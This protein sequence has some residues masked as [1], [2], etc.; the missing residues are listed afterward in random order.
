MGANRTRIP[1]IVNT[2]KGPR[3]RTRMAGESMERDQRRIRRRDAFSPMDRKPMFTQDK[4]ERMQDKDMEARRQERKQRREERKQT[5]GDS[6][7]EQRKERRRSR[8]EM[9][10]GSGENRRIF[11]KITTRSE[12]S[13]RRRRNRTNMAPTKRDQNI[14]DKEI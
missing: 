4:E 1:R 14:A 13:E 12:R 9:D 5:F 6:F 11:R 7:R 3:E 2:P 10:E 8:R